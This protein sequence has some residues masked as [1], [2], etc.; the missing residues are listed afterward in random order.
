[1]STIRI[2]AVLYGPADR[3]AVAAP[4]PL[5]PREDRPTEPIGWRR[6]RTDDGRIELEHAGAVEVP[7]TIYY[8]RALRRGDIKRAAPA[9][10]PKPKRKAASSTTA[11]S[12][13]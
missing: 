9:P 13:E 6:V 7:N 10:K 8:R 4:G 5:L 11:E 2:E 1:M 12:Q 3:R